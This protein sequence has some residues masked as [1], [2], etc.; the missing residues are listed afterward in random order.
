M[1]MDDGSFLKWATGTIIG[2]LSIV[3]GSYK[4][5]QSQI[6]KHKAATDKS[7]EKH[8][9]EVHAAEC[10]DEKSCKEDRDHLVDHMK[11]MA[12]DHAT[13]SKIIFLEIKSINDKLFDMAKDGN[14]GK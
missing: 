5:T 10:V 12:T 2:I 3:F 9:A 4:F 11:R 14:H 7:I 8:K 1:Q 6:D 13:S